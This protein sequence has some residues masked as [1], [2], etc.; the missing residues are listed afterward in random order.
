[1]ATA[2]RDGAVT[3][4]PLLSHLPTERGMTVMTLRRPEADGNTRDSKSG[5][6]DPG[7][8][9]V[10]LTLR[11]VVILSGGLV[12]GIVTGILTYFAVHNP[13]E[14]VLAGIPACV[15][16]ISFLDVLID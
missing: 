6:S 3:F 16:A 13:P 2:P 12:A 9:R 4:H 5:P 14:A 11:D 10:S 15:G 1:M 7:S 8:R